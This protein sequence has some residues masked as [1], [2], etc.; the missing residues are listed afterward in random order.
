MTTSTTNPGVREA[1]ERL[2]KHVRLRAERRL[3]HLHYWD[4][5]SSIYCSNRRDAARQ[6]AAEARAANPSEWVSEKSL[7]R[8]AA[9]F[10]R[11]GLLGLVD[12]R[13]RK[14]IER[15]AAAR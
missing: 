4:E 6:V 7:Y 12:Q 11:F 3:Q 2:P 10:H 5:L 9:R 13:F 15:E 14:A 1:F 8:W